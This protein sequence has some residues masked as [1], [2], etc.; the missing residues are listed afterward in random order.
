MLTRVIVISCENLC[1]IVLKITGKDSKTYFKSVLPSYKNHSTGSYMME[2]LVF[3]QL[4]HVIP[5]VSFYSPINIR[6]PLVF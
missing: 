3:N 5:L 6:K 4:T 1:G 2:T